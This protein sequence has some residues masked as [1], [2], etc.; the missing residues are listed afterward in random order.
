MAIL[1]TCGHNI[2]SE[3]SPSYLAT[4]LAIGIKIAQA[5][6]LHRLG[7]E[8]FEVDAPSSAMLIEREVG[9][10]VWWV[11]TVQG[12]FVLLYDT[13]HPLYPDFRLVCGTL[14]R[15]LLYQYESIQ[16]AFTDRLLR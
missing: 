1:A 14:P 15:C 12:E 11:L 10:R 7:S 13:L 9:K 5:L 6:N 2:V 8:I 16:Y 3:D 4:L